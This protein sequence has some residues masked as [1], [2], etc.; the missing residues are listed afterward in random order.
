MYSCGCVQSPKETHRCLWWCSSHSHWWHLVTIQGAVLTE[1]KAARCNPSAQLQPSIQI[2]IS[3]LSC[4]GPTKHR[5][6]E[7]ICDS[8]PAHQSKPV[9][10]GVCGTYPG[11]AW[12]QW[13][14]GYGR[15]YS[16]LL[17]LYSCWVSWKCTDSDQTT[18][19]PLS[20][21][22]GSWCRQASEQGW[23]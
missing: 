16:K 18:S 11:V 23:P 22:V 4:L 7:W 20:T 2:H 3:S 5:W 6:S 8:H 17:T 15:F 21:P 19:C 1:P 10:S 14:N 9:H 13:W 12:K